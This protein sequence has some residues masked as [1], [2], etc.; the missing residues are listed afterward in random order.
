MKAMLSRCCSRHAAAPC[1]LCQI[2]SCMITILQECDISCSVKHT[3]TI[4]MEALQ[5]DAPI[6]I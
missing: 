5:S 6:R 2:M 3:D 1:M 4:I